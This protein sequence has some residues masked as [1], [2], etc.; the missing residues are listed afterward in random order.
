MRLRRSFPAAVALAVLAG[1][2]GSGSEIYSAPEV[3]KALRNRGFNVEILSKSAVEFLKTFPEATPKG[4]RSVVTQRGT[5]GAVVDPTAFV[6]TAWIFGSADEA[7]CTAP[8][9]FTTCLEKSNVVVVVRKDGAGPAGGA[10]D[11]LD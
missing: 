11:D 1:C 6:I 9:E 7:T 5:T 8:N 10:L 2:G 3:A 4:V